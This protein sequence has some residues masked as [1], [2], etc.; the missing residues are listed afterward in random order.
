MIRMK[1]II[2]QWSSNLYYTLLMPYLVLGLFSAI[3]WFG[4]PF[5]SISNNAIFEQP[6]KRFYT[7]LLLFAAWA[8][9]ITVMDKPKTPK[10]PPTPNHPD[11]TKKLDFLTG[12]FKGAIGFL[13]KTVINKNGKNSSLAHLPWYLLIGASGSGKTSLLAN[14][15]IHFILSKQFKHEAT[16]IIPPSDVCDWWVTRDSVLVDVPGFYLH[17]RLKNVANAS[18][19]T[20]EKIAMHAMLWQSLLDLIKKFRGENAINGVI[21]AVALSDLMSQPNQKKER[22]IYHLR[23]RIIDLKAKFGANIPFYLVITKCD[24]LPGFTEFFSDIGMDELSQAW[25]VTIPTVNKAETIADVFADRF[26]ALIKR[27]NKQL[28]WRIHQ[29]RNPLMRPFIKDFPLQVEHMKDNIASLLKNLTLQENAFHLQGVYLT[30]AMQYAEP[31]SSE[32]PIAA[33]HAAAESKT[34]AIQIL[35]NPFMRTRAYFIRQFLLQGLSG[36]ADHHPKTTKKWQ[37]RP[38]LYAT[39]LGLIIIASLLLGKEVRL[40]LQQTD[41]IRDSLTQYQEGLKRHDVEL[42]K[43]LPLLNALQKTSVNS[44]QADLL[45]ST[46]TQQN[47][48]TAYQQALQNIIVPEIKND[49]EK[50]LQSN[51]GKN[52]AQLYAALQ[53]Y[54]M[55]ADSQHLQPDVI[56]N[57]L[58]L[59]VPAAIS[60]QGAD[61]II[62]HIRA[63]FS[64]SWQQQELNN[65]VINQARKQLLSLTPVQL[66]LVILK[67]MASNNFDTTISLGTD[68]N[69]PPTLVNKQIAN[70]VPYMFTGDAFQ[71]VYSQ[72]IDTA[73][74]EAVHSNW[75]LGNTN[76][77]SSTTSTALAEQLR[78]LYVSNYIDVW[79]S[80][81]ANIQLATP[82]NLSQ[83]DAMIANLT[84]T[85]SPLLQLLKTIKQNTNY[86]PL[87]AAS[88][89]LSALSGLITSSNYQQS[90]PLYKIFT[91]L[92]QV[93]S[94]IQSILTA[95]DINH[96]AF[97]AASARMQ[98]NSSI[99]ANDALSQLFT[100]ANTSPEPVRN[101]LTQIAAASWHFVLQN[102]GIYVENQW[103][104]NIL[105]IYHAQ[106]AN[107]FP[108]TPDATQDVSLD[109]FNQLLGAQGTLNNFYNSYLSAFVD[110]SNNQPR[111]KKINN[112]QM[113]FSQVALDQLQQAMQLQHIFFPHGENKIALKFTLKPVILSPNTKSVRLSINGQEIEHDRSLPQIPQYL[114]W[115]GSSN[116]L[117]QT[118]LSLATWQNMPLNNTI[119]GDWAWLRLVNEATPRIFSQKEVL[120]HFKVDG[121][122]AKYLLFTQGNVN[123][124]LVNNL[125]QFKLPE[126]LT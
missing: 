63:A 19:Q 18:A 98:N 78:T 28:I 79:E 25:G 3:I 15:N 112:D 44:A 60:Q 56:A 67:N 40:N 17:S 100:I 5:I 97:Q 89:K 64:Q 113:P 119:S 84:S 91:S 107:R 126:Q 26:N 106:F 66:A 108:F 34:T 81:L 101:W 29:E 37:H 11:F 45:S 123:P 53:A 62:K 31:S 103:K 87:L 24:L 16:K 9:K 111:W 46:E 92:N 116:T 22:I 96:A 32:E 95:N 23:Q 65:N 39:A 58:I 1:Q 38:K 115:P 71:L 122:M 88:P 75:V 104:N 77:S 49:L 110:N 68:G 80:L 21:I 7:I 4:G 30:S 20:K 70:Q 114:T 8:L 85:N 69:N 6:E 55:L 13:H 42:A 61:Q 72:Q 59:V 90:D 86:P 51:N 47:A 125:R 35:R 83:V 82:A 73:A 10:I 124:F 94:Y 109:Q 52:P 33:T 50:Y 41:V 54:L 48:N 117:H 105:A 36:A 12:R 76:S 14:S 120:L 74:N 93:H 43:A 27:L 57:T 121:H 2:K 102:A 118:Q 99:P